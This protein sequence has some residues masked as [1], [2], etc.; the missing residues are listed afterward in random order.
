MNKK[1]ERILGKTT[2]PSMIYLM[3]YAAR[4]KKRWGVWTDP[5]EKP[6]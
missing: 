5:N 3:M 2:H 1:L 4:L 6:D